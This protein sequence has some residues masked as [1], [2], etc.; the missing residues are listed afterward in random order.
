MKKNESKPLKN[1]LIAFLIFIIVILLTFYIFSWYKI[2]EE[3]KMVSPFSVFCSQLEYSELGNSLIET[4]NNYF[5]Y[6]SSSNNSKIYNLE[7]KIKKIVVDNDLQGKIYYLNVANE[8]KDANFYENINNKL[9]LSDKKITHLPAI[10]YYN[11]TA[12]EDVINSNDK[13]LFSVNEFNKLIKK[14]KVEQ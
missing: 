7:K 12:A 6:V 13:E 5:I 3:K 4:P 2:Y 1:Y 8:K 11:G 14:Y 9:N 10:I